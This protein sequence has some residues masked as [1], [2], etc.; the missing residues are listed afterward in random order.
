MGKE[1]AC[2]PEPCSRGHCS[3]EAIVST[4]ERGQMVLPKDLRTKAGIRP[5]DKLAV[6]AWEKEGTVCCIMLI[7][8]DQLSD[9]VKN[10]VGPILGEAW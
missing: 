6:V 9:P 2:C 1:N 10:V 4:D 3:V 5:G 7:P 8:A